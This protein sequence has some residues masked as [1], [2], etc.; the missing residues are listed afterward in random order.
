MNGIE[1]WGEPQGALYAPS[2]VDPS[3]EREIA[4]AVDATPWDR[5]DGM[6]RRVQHYGYRY[7][8]RS[9][10]LPERAGDLPGW[11]QDLSRRLVEAG[12]FEGP[13]EQVIVNEYVGLQGIGRHTDSRVFAD[14]IATVSL[15]AAWPM[16]FRRSGRAVT[17]VLE[18]RSALLI[19]GPSRYDWTHEIVRAERGPGEGRRLSLTFRRLA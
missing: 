14:G 17:R 18:Q 6:I 1:A 13:A 19:A 15:L 4:G 2:F 11:A 5:V 12:L 3:E 8:Y 16:V 7:E 10:G 9:R